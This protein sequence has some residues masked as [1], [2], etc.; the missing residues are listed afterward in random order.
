LT[1]KVLDTWL[2]DARETLELDALALE[3]EEL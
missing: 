3:L 2:A 1:A